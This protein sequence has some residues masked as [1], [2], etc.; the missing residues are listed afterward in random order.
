VFSGNGRASAEV[1]Y[2]AETG[3]GKE[4]TGWT[5]RPRVQWSVSGKGRLDVRYAWT[6]FT[7]LTG[8]TGISG[9]GSPS[10]T[11]GQRL[12]VI[13]EHRITQNIVLTGAVLMNAPE[14]L[15]RIVEGRMEVRGSF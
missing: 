1:S 14:G 13:G 10:L 7:T 8:F 4:A 12:D 6:R 5:V 15:E 11:E 3:E 9:P 2:S